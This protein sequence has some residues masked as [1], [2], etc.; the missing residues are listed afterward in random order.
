[1]H[2]E[3]HVEALTGETDRP[4]IEPRN[5]SSGMPT[6]LSEAE[7]NTEHDDNRKSCADP[8]RSETLSMSGSLS[9]GSSEISSVSGVVWPDRAGKVHDR[10]PAIDADEKS[11]MPI[12]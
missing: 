7:G 6:L 11:D 3:V 4:A 12:L 9:Y 10:N 1:M 2:R 8:A 5:I